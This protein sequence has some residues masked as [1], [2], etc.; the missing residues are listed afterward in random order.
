MTKKETFIVRR[1]MNQI[2]FIPSGDTVTKFNG[3]ILATETGAF[4]WEHIEEVNSPEEMAKLL[5]E[6]FDVSYEEALA[7]VTA[8]FD[9]F[10]KAGWIE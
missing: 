2:M 4:I 9:Q 8:L 10:Q 7:D 5:I 3:M 6:E 1:A